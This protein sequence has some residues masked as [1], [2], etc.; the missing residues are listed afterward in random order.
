MQPSERIEIE[1]SVAKEIIALK[2]SYMT[3]CKSRAFKDV[4]EKGYFKEEAARLVM[5]KS[6]N[7]LPADREKYIDNMIIG[8]GSLANWFDLIVQRGTD[9]EFA[10]ADMEQVRADML[11]E[12]VS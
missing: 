3:L 7:N 9:M 11:V 8:I 10:M 6:N 1:I 5:A 2:N 12:E 4:I